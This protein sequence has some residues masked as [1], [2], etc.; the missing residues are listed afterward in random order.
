MSRRHCDDG[1]FGAELVERLL[2]GGRELRGK[3]EDERATLARKLEARVRLAEIERDGALVQ[4]SDQGQNAMRRAGGVDE[5]WTLGPEQSFETTCHRR[6]T[7]HAP[8][9]R[10]SRWSC[11]Q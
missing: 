1:T 6:I 2:E 9:Q 4:P 3:E 10:E 5:R 8:C 7:K 11:E